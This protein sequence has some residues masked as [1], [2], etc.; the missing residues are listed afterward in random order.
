MMELKPTPELKKQIAAALARL[1]KYPAW[2]RRELQRDW[3]WN[4]SLRD[5]QK[6]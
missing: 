6:D 5:R 4:D 3:D 1:K 2:V